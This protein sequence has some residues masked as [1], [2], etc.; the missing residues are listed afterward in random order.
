M[1]KNDDFSVLTTAQEA[2]PAFEAAVLDAEQEISG[3]FR[4]F[5]FSTKLIS[6]KARAIGDTWF[7][8][9]EHVVRRGVRFRLVVSD[10]DPVMA[11]PLHETTWRT[12][13]QAAALAEVLGPEAAERFIV[14]PSMHP[15]R[16][17]VLP[18][19]TF[20]PTVLAKMRARLRTLNKARLER[21]AIGLDPQALPTL[22]TVSHHQKMA[23][24]DRQVLYIGG[25]DLNPRRFDTPDHDCIAAATWSDVQLLL[26]GDEAE[27]AAQHLDTFL[28]EI[29]GR[30]PARPGR[31]I[32]RTLSAPRRVNVWAL[33]PRTLLR[34][35]EED[36]VQAFQK[37]RHL[38]Y[39]E[40]QFLRSSIIADALIAAAEDRAKLSLILVLPA[41]PEDVAF[42]GNL[43]LDARY[44]M[45]LGAK[46]VQRVQAA[47]DGRGCI[48]TPVLPR[49]AARDAVSVL[50]GSP[51]IHVHNKVLICDD[52]FA[53]VGS[54]N[55]NGRS[56]RWDT[57]TA[58]RITERD[59]IDKLWR[60]CCAHWWSDLPEEGR[61]IETAA[62]WWQ[63][64]VKRN[65]VSLPERRNG[66]LVS[67]D[68][69]K[70]QDYQQHLPGV[71]EDI[72]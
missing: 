15:A 53:M 3:G 28:D 22:N 12:M 19:L 49:M 26:R 70:M 46:N 2:W 39:I 67:H 5:D 7:D 13:R 10:F 36:H 45:A 63:T 50:A 72:V 27:E 54:A 24:I 37:A 57:E 41:V 8:L 55:L 18:W 60:A 64:A 69:E 61:A 56:M 21:Q 38:I 20:L 25:L 66:F 43:G 52:D 35:I 11:T 23:V 65:T 59:R 17:G 42:E 47:F 40:T 1:P 29:S 34:E 14:V 6:E 16:A 9:I 4:I 31:H 71:T 30:K 58:L 48:A 33:S 32:R 44:G 51:I 62:A 68:A